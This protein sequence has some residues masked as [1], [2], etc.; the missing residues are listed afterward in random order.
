MKATHLLQGLRQ[1]VLEDL[2][3]Y[4]VVKKTKENKELQ[5]ETEKEKKRAEAIWTRLS[6]LKFLQNKECKSRNKDLKKARENR[7]FWDGMIW[8]KGSERKKRKEIKANIFGEGK[9]TK[10][11]NTIK[12]EE[13]KR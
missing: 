9:N 1:P 13:R 4:H 6:C 3:I 2:S 7:F 11:Y 8:Q 5:R 10:K 12:K